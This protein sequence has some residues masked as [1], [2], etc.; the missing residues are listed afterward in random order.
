MTTINQVAKQ[1]VEA[2]IDMDYVADCGFKTV[3][4]VYKAEFAHNHHLTANPTN[5]KDY[6]QGL[7]SVCEVPFY[8]SDILELL[9]K[10]GIT[11]KSAD[12]QYTLIEQYWYACGNQLFLIIKSGK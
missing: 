8:N 2:A 7:P 12:A 6:L 1:I 3:G 11:R 4:E 9:E 10:N 5:C